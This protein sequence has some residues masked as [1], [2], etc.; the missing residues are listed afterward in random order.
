LTLVIGP[1]GQCKAY[2]NG[3][4]QTQSAEW[5]WT[6]SETGVASISGSGVV[7]AVALGTTVVSAM[8]QGLT[9]R[10]SVTVS[11]PAPPV[12]S[13]MVSGSRDD[14]GRPPAQVVDA[15]NTIFFYY[16]SSPNPVYFYKQYSYRLDYGDGTSDTLG[17]GAPPFTHVYRSI[18]T[19]VATL[20]ITSPFGEVSTATASPV[21]KGL[22]GNWSTNF[23]QS[24]C[25]APGVRSLSLVQAGTAL[26]GTYLGPSGSVPFSGS[27][28][29]IR[30]VLG[31]YVTLT[32]ANGSITFT[33]DHADSG[34][35]PDVESIRLFSSEPC[36]KG[37][38]LIFRRQ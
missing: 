36:L 11:L 8:L 18:G 34:V 29:G 23:V 33:S 15:M 38:T 16:E 10:A 14:L 1:S 13:V 30:T 35:S 5:Q 31:H 19:F 7:T 4:D 20:T 2:L 12:A 37:V 22:S 6:S 9:A 21:V 26:S 24:G 17:P 28:S 27:M 3:I 32:L 25:A